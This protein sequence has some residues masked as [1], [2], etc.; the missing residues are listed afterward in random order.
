M[1]IASSRSQRPTN[2][3]NVV[4]Q[5]EALNNAAKTTNNEFAALSIRINATTAIQELCFLEHFASLPLRDVSVAELRNHFVNGWNTE[6]ILGMTASSLTDDALPSGLQWA[7]PMAYYASYSVAIAYYKAAG[8]TESSHAAVIRKFGSLA[9]QKKYPACIAFYADGPRP[10]IF[11]GAEFDANFSTLARPADVGDA[12]KI[13]A[14]FLSGTRKIDLAEKKKDMKFFTKTGKRKLAFKMDDWIKVSDKLGKTSLL[15]L[16]YR[17]RIK[18]N[19][20]DIDTFLS[21]EIDGAGIF[22]S[23]RQVVSTL[24][25]VHEAF[26]AKQLGA[27]KFEQILSEVPP[28]EFGFVVQRYRSFRDLL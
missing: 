17:K 22:R 11:A 5:N 7:F 13:I 8:F 23:L 27:A 6:R 20:R 9:A 16:L 21:P 24:N 25:L 14:S 28:G 1:L 12:N 4:A 3:D 10:C 2:L 26:V 19:Y 15:S 18:A